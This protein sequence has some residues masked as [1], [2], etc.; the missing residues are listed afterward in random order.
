MKWIAHDAHIFRGNSGGPLVNLKGEI[1][2]INE[3]RFGL[4]GAIPSEIASFVAKELIAAGV[5]RRI[6]VGAYF[7]PLLKSA[8]VGAALQGVLVCEVASG[9]W[10]AVAGLGKD[11]ESSRHSYCWN[12]ESR[13]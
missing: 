3:G 2:G 7:Q 5:V 13:C 9:G 1:V 11:R 4:S 6:S 10:A 8:T 12:G